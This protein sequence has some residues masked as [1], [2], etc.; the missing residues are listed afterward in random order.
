MEIMQ[1][2]G[3]FTRWLYRGGESGETL[4]LFSLVGGNGLHFILSPRYSGEQKFAASLVSWSE[5]FSLA[6]INIQSSCNAFLEILILVVI[7]LFF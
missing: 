5:S 4:F 3:Y 1:R 2:D 6:I 7:L